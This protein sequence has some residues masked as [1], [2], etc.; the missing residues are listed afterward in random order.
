MFGKMMALLLLAAGGWLS[1]TIISQRPNQKTDGI[2]GRWD[3]TVQSANATYPS[4]LEVKQDNN[5]LMG[6]LC[7]AHRPRNASPESRVC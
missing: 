4:W 5:K 3:L 6:P 7:R 2:L 1:S